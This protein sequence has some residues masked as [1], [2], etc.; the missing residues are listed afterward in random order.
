MLRKLLPIFLAV[1]IAAAAA[2]SRITRTVDTART[3]GVA[4]SVHRLAQSR[5]D[6]GAVDPQ[7]A[8]NDMI[9]L[10]KPSEAQQTDL[11]R[12]LT[13][14]QN[15]SSAQFHKWLSPEQFGDRFGLS[16]SDH[17]KIAGWLTA[18]GFK[19]NTAA[20][21]RNWVSFNGS[22]AQV[23]RVFHTSIHR[24]RVNGES[25]IANATDLAVPEAFA[26]V[27]GGFLG[28]NDFQL[29][30][31]AHVVVPPGPDFN[32]GTSHYLSP[33]DFGTIYDLTPVI[34]SGLD[35]TGQSIAIV[36]E[37]DVLISDIRAFRTR[38]GL[39]ANDPKMV[40][41][42]A[43][44]GF[45]GAQLEGNLDL[46]WAGALAPNATIY[47]VY[48]Q[49]A[50]TA[51]LAA[52]NLNVAPVIS[53][54]YGTCEVDASQPFFRS[55][56]QQGNAQGITLLSA[57]G[58]SGAAGC[59]AQDTQPL[60]TEGR[61]VDFP[62]VMPEVTAV[63]GTQFAEGTGTYWGTSN[64]PVGGSAL[65][66][67]PEKAWNE[68]GTA[69]LGATG[70]GVSGFYTQPAWQ[71]GSGVPLD[72]F[73]HVPD[74]SL[75]AAGHDGYLIIYNGGLGAVGG[76]S[77]STPSMAAL[78]ALLNQWQIAN[79]TQK[80]PGLGNINPQLYRLAQAAPSIYH[81]VIAGDNMVTC[82]QGTQDCSTGS[83]G[84]PAV[85]G[86][87]MATGLGSVD[88]RAMLTAWN[89]AQNAVTVTL[90]TSKGNPTVND[91]IQMT[92]VVTPA[93]GT[94]T[95]T[96]TV[97]F[98]YNNI[99][100]G[101]APL[102]TVGGQQ[103]ASVSVPV[104]VLGAGN[105]LIGAIY[106]GDSAFSGGGAIT[107]LLITQPRTGAAGITITGPSSVW[108][109]PADAL[110]LSWQS[111]ITLA[112]GAGVPAIV[113]G[114]SID[115]RQ[116]SVFGY[117]PSPDLRANSTLTV[118][119]TFR[120]LNGPV[121]KTFV[122]T[123]I[124][125]GNNNWTRQI[126]ITFMP[127]PIYDYF[128]FNATPLTMVQDP[129]AVATC[130]WSTL[131]DIDDAGGFQNTVSAFFVGGESYTARV[132]SIFGTPRL[133]SFGS[134]QG[135]LCFGG[136]TPP[137]NEE[138]EVD[139]SDG[140]VQI[141]TVSFG[142][143]VTNP[144][145]LAV[146]PA[147]ISLTSAAP[148]QSLAITATKPWTVAVF[149]ANRT[150]SWLSASVR[151]GSGNGQIVLKASPAGF[152]PGIYRAN[153][154]IE[155]DLS[156]PQY[157]NIPV[158][159]VL[160]GS[161]S[162]TAISGV[163]NSASYDTVVSPGTT[164]AIFGTQLANATATAPLVSPYAYSLGGVS[165]TVN[166]I[167]AAILF[168]SATQVN[169]QAPYEVAAGPGVIGINNNGQVAGFALN[170]SPAA[171]GIFVDPTSGNASGAASV[172]AGAYATV[173]LTGS[174][175]VTPALKSAYAVP[176]GTAAASLPKPVLPLTVTV[177][178]VQAFVQFA[179][180]IPGALSVTQVNFLVPASIAVGV[181]PVVVTIGGV[182]SKVANI[183]VAAPPTP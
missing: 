32:S 106:S 183:L 4:G 121:V 51:I 149:P 116:Q 179:G 45:N 164:V 92:M 176:T 11:D 117:L 125:A 138:I 25:H 69:G 141:L 159:F 97:N 154:V 144:G 33:A 110:G 161:T 147:T 94:G 52:I 167:P 127:L 143:P 165:A 163:V 54:S 1:S 37:S 48:G 130:Q 122:F 19:V 81:D 55:I 62:A 12:L 17:S 157:V 142:P 73:R 10:I 34:Q 112:E 162:G 134:L 156:T 151:S 66:Y 27:V 108:P 166:G 67:I 79:G 71:T 145:S 171:P 14:Q 109:Q 153:V 77:C 20:R 68:S 118:P 136:I 120:A 44:P 2:P 160:G 63:G 61:M 90:T 3:R 13:D 133:T 132:P 148:S 26:D 124:D 50:F 49:S 8:L 16:A 15:P 114:I 126:Q 173:Y 83:F 140:A 29:K 23:S 46:E 82:M 58:D 135:K 169:V 98:V 74:I 75:S 40:P 172:V 91:T 99:P 137:A 139:L 113:T 152:E 84:D 60:A 180:T 42:G 22:A 129:T 158:T 175:E 7:T 70:G 170:I 102:V 36:G 155:S 72:G 86:Y 21:G 78:I 174:G 87:D 6:V 146:S 59:D 178:G 103:A 100:L 85:A 95:P 18:S 111:A 47:Y 31:M 35:G 101:S 115:G 80:Q 104:Y 119:F 150:T 93:S 56:A 107:R 9:L 53:I 43:D 123:G 181:Q 41:Y 28:I 65:S 64:S 128:N 88:A 30:S 182:S 89:T 131:I 57:S 38:F 177:G 5:Y 24:F 96:G 168:T 39:A 76:T 105:P